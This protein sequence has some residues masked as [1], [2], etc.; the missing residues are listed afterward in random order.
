[1]IVSA[2]APE[3]PIPRD[4]EGVERHGFPPH[5][6]PPIRYAVPMPHHK[7]GAHPLDASLRRSERLTVMI[8]P[9]DLD[10]LRQLADGWGVSVSAAGWAML[11]D[12]L[13]ELRSQ[14]PATGTTGAILLAA[15]RRVVKRAGDA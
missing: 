14:P 8:R 3:R 7:H 12:L 2:P 6:A 11:A 5:P 13:A 9:G 4:G 1:M 10:D 15:S